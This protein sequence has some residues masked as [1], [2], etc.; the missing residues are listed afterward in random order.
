PISTRRATTFS[1]CSSL[2]RSSITTTIVPAASNTCVMLLV[3]LV[4]G[5][6]FAV[7]RPPLEPARFV[8]D[9]FEQPRDRVG[10]KRSLARAAAHVR[11]HLLLALG[12][13]TLDPLGL[14]DAADLH[15]DP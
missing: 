5:R 11:E 14:F 9:A 4:R 3:R 6:L 10:A 7:H 1:I 12:L 8:D 15:R 13:V 2:A